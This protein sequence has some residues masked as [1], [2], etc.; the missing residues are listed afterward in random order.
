MGQP[1][2]MRYGA[3]HK[4][5]AVNYHLMMMMGQSLTWKDKSKV[6]VT[7]QLELCFTSTGDL[8][9]IMTKGERS[10]VTLGVAAELK[11]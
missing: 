5:G 2:F 1:L 7:D 4:F 6:K 8:V 3:K 10:N 11:I 9:E